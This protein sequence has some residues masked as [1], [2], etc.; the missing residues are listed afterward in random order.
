MKYREIGKRTKFPNRFVCGN[1]RADCQ[2]A[3]QDHVKS[4]AALWLA[5]QFGST[6]RSLTTR[7]SK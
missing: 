1:M 7:K 6:R 2:G 5:G 4:F 3:L